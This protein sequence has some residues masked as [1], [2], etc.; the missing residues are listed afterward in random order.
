MKIILNEQALNLLDQIEKTNILPE[1]DT[2]G[3]FFDLE[4]D[5]WVAFKILNKVIGFATFGTHKEAL[6]WVIR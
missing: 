6:N 1:E 3:V 4:F 5:N 2:G